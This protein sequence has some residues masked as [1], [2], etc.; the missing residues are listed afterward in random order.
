MI[1][2]YL[3]ARAQLLGGRAPVQCVDIPLEQVLPLLDRACREELAAHR[4]TLHDPAIGYFPVVSEVDPAALARRLR[5]RRSARIAHAEW[6]RVTTGL[7][8]FATWL[9]LVLPCVG[10]PLGL[11]YALTDE[12]RSSVGAHMLLVGVVSVVLHFIAWFVRSAVLT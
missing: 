10:L 8:G 6:V 7:T 9:P 3:D 11:V 2:V 12:K 5:E 1:R 4:S